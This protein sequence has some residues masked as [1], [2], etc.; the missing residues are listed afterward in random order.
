MYNKPMAVYFY[1]GEEDFLIDSE[2]EKMRAKLN[3]DFVSMSYRVLDN[4]EFPELINALRTT[5]MMFGE[6]LYIINAEKY[7]SSQK[8]YFE[9]SELADIEDALQNNPETLNIV[10]VVKLP[11]DEGRKIDTRK[12]LYKILSKFNSEEFQPFKTYKTD[13]IAGWIKRHAK[14]KDLVLT[15]DAVNM[16]IELL[17]NNLRQF[18]TELDKL[19]LIAYPEKTVTKKMVEDIAISNQ[20]LFNITDLIMKNSK[21]KALLE[22][23][24]LTDKKHPL[25]ILA[26]I[27]TMLR[28]W[29]IIKLKSSASSSEVSKLVGMHEF[30]VKQTLQKLKN[31]SV[32]D[33]VRL[34]Q[35]LYSAEC[36]IKSGEAL[37][38]NSEVEIALIK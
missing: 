26:A 33:L 24:K 34:K 15:D 27:Q 11:R 20:D 35:N 38:V 7:F 23:K 21:D 12:K 28:K 9:D 37:D 18:D 13:E 31:L 25:E 17:G 5:P 8:N 3:P 4:P 14:K 2:L 19:K 22:F 30:V 16:L 29:I 36:K 10:F 6:S 1:Y 32:K